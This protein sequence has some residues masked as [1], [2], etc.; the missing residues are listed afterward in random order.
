MN[1]RIDTHPSRRRIAELFQNKPYCFSR[2]GNLQQTVVPKETFYEELSQSVFTIA[3]PGY[4]PDTVRLWEAIVF[5]AIPIVKHSELDD[6]YADLPVL[7]VD[8]WEEVDEALMH[9]KRVEIANKKVS[10][11]KAYFD[12]WAQKIEVYQAQVRS[13][14]NN[15]SS[16]E[17]TR[18][19]S[20]TLNTLAQLIKDK[21]SGKDKLLFKGA[22][23]GLRPFE[24][25]DRCPSLAEIYVQDPWGSWGH[26]QAGAHLKSFVPG[27]LQA[28]YSKMHPINFYDHPYSKFPQGKKGKPCFSRS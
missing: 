12:Y 21:T 27:D 3:P 25:A 10:V 26:E 17:A 28:R 14:N 7:L 8:E 2:I 4:G 13:G 22:A 23:M 19:K 15:F 18:F 6:L 1:I 5:G 16:I 11:E 20:E 9:R 24:C